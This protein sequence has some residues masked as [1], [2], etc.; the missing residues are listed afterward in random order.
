[1]GELLP[2][3]RPRNLGQSC[4]DIFPA[5]HGQPITGS[6]ILS[7][8]ATIER[9]KKASSDSSSSGSIS[10]ANT[11]YYQQESS[12]L[13][14]QISNLQNNNRNMVGECLGALNLRELKNLETKVERAIGKIRSKKNELLFA[15]IEYMQKRQE[16]DLHQNNQYLRAKIA[17]T[18]RGQ[19][20]MNLMPGSSDQY[21]GLV[22]SQPFDY[23]Q[24]SDDYHRQD[25]TSL[26]LTGK[27][28]HGK[29]R[30]VE[31]GVQGVDEW[32]Q[33]VVEGLHDFINGVV[34]N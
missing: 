34:A 33:P 12:K 2:S 15:E 13:R 27:I 17:E 4:C 5:W 22:Q 6:R 30:A 3:L 7:V 24:P 25:Q 1:M 9:Y 16:I 28:D 19:Q 20:H 11:Q 26:Q 23:L 8:K 10:E 29:M 18:E 32:L 31:I 21:H 14:A